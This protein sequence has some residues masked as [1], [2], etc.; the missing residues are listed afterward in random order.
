MLAAGLAV[1][2]PSQPLGFLLARPAQKCHFDDEGE[3]RK[4]KAAISDTADD[5][6]FGLLHALEFIRGFAADEWH[7]QRISEG[8]AA[9]QIVA[10][11]ERPAGLSFGNQRVRVTSFCRVVRNGGDDDARALEDAGAD[12]IGPAD[13]AWKAGEGGN[14]VLAA[15]FAPWRGG[16]PDPVFRFQKGQ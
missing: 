8:L 14:H 11:E 5:T 1:Q 15:I 12:E 7:A 9:L 13:G 2:K 6:D 4:I 16:Q 3:I 10:E